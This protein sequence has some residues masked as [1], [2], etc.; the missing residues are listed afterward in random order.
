M[1]VHAHGHNHPPQLCLVNHG[2]ASVTGFQ[3]FAMS[4]A[5]DF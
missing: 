5:S 2:A 4:A 3:G 1:H